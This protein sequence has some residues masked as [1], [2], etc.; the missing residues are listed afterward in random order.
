MRIVFAYPPYSKRGEFPHL[1]QNRQTRYTK[2]AQVRIYPVVPSSLLT[3]VAKKGHSALLLDAINRRL[4]EQEY[5]AELRSF[6]PEMIV[7]ESKTPIMRKLWREV[8]RLKRWFPRAMIVIVGDH[9]TALP[10]ETLGN[11]PCDYI[12]LGGDYDAVVAALVDFLVEGGALPEGV[13]SRDCPS[14]AQAW[15]VDDLDVLPPPDRELTRWRDYGEAYLMRPAMYILSGRG[16][17][18]KGRSHRG[19]S[20]CSWQHNLWCGSARLRSPEK[21]VAE[22]G[23]LARRYGVREFFDDNES[24]GFWDREWTSE[25]CGRLRAE[26]LPGRTVISSNARADALTDEVCRD[27]ATSGFRL[28]KV[29][30]ESASDE[31][32][33][34][35]GKGET[36]GEIRAGVKRAKDYGLRV[37]LTIMVGY[38]WET[39]EDVRGTFELARELLTYKARIGDSLQCSIVVPYPGTPLYKEATRRGWNAVDPLDY[40]KYDMDTNVLTTPVDTTQW[41]GRFWRLYLD[42]AYVLKLLASVRSLREFHLGFR[43]LVSLFGHI[44]DYDVAASAECDSMTEALSGH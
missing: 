21:V 27:L 44:R 5:E 29:G 39:Q 41:A 10:E 9:V 8:G 36:A 32:L 11:C 4:S 7:V 37:L 15:L 34:R 24:G 13:V 43:G 17:G 30:L 26:G 12:A 14:A 2:S 35:L 23:D 33:Q 19:C 25:L 40:E 1:S 16:C 22:I 20:F 28:L 6:E 31:T 3:I 42:Q 38:P 18:R